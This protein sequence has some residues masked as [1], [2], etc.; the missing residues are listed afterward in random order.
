MAGV[1]MR[2]ACAAAVLVGAVALA[3]VRDGQPVSA[4]E[5]GKGEL[6]ADLARVPRDAF[7]V[8]SVRLADYW[9]SPGGK[10]VKE[11][12]AKE[13]PEALE[14]FKKSFGIG[15]DDVERI[16]TVVAGPR[17]GEP[18][19]F[20]GTARP[21]DRAKVRDAALPGAKEEKVK[22]QVVYVS[23][24]EGRAMSFLG[25][26]AFV[27]GRPQEVAALL[28]KAPARE[29]PL[30]DVL[31]AAAEKH[32]LVFGMDPR[33]LAGVQLPQ[34]AEPF[35]PLL[36]A[37]SA[38]VTLDV[39]KAVKA[40]ARATFPGEDDAK[41]GQKAVEKLLGVARMQ[42]PELIKM[43][44][45]QKDFPAEV[46][47]LLKDAEG[48]AKALKVEQ[49]GAALE[50]TVTLE[51]DPANA[52]VAVVEAVQKVREAAARIQSVNNL[53][54]LALAMHSYHDANGTFP[55]HAV[56]SK[57]GKPLLS[58]RVLLLPYLEENKL[59]EE[60]KLDEPWDSEHNKKL[61]EKMPKLFACPAAKAGPPDTV[62]QAFVGP[63]AGF[64]GKKGLKITDYT[65]GTS[66]T[67]MFVEAATAVPWTKPEDL[68]FDPAK[69]LPKLGGHSKGGFNASLFD[70]S[71]R[72]IS[73]S[74]KAETL[75]A[76]IT[77]NG[78]EVLGD[79]F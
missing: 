58:W 53:K 6:P 37:K 60:F 10:A 5:R 38:V 79:D 34:E 77:R 7:V 30:D 73:N 41:N 66:N 36:K 8:A 74:V 48:A 13:A 28:E 59:Y 78:G 54:Q 27:A 18:L 75:K 39:D 64:E 69:P 3:L 9:N 21:L 40:T 23:E 33:A 50:S 44:S 12:L 49:K 63:G 47:K 43:A 2:A 70:G 52:S 11:K 20:V 76:A 55:P 24:K 15:V 67:I 65:D 51:T 62:Y 4:Q 17:S 42:L 31:A 68:P 56:Y 57:D 32:L 22:D 45:E 25:D 16:T 29:G 35:R 72:F 61:L 14:Q 19:T 26:S 1:R 71:V 46:V